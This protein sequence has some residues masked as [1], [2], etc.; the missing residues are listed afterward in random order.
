MWR[1]EKNAARGPRRRTE[2]LVRKG[3]LKLG[4]ST[5][6][7]LLVRGGYQET[8][9]RVPLESL[10]LSHPDRIGYTASPWWVLRWLLPRSDVRPSDVFVEFG[11]G[12]GRVVLDAARRYP[13]RRVIGVELSPDLSEVARRLVARERNRLRCRDVRIDTADATEYSVPDDMTYAY[14]Y[15]PFNGDTFERVCANIVASLDRAPRPLH[16]IYLNP[17]DHETLAATGRFRL[18][19]RVHTTRLVFPVKAAIYEAE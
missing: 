10:G 4:Q 5:A 6:G 1:L 19:R 2:D 16:L 8:A 15:N 14:L 13:F 17:A 18:V 7:Q 3:I 11:C 12:K 9:D